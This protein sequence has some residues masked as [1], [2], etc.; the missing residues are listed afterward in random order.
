M[1]YMLIQHRNGVPQ[2]GAPCV[3]QDGAALSAAAVAGC[4]RRPESRAARACRWPRRDRLPQ[5]GERPVS[6]KSIFDRDVRYI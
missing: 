3:L 5:A 6:S 2:A 4:P 1:M